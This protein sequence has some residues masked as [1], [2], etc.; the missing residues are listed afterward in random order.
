MRQ[1][2]PASISARSASM[3][4]RRRRCKACFA[5]VEAEVGPVAVCLFNAGSNVNKPLLETTEK[6]ITSLGDSQLRAARSA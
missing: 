1:G 6:L 5:R 3:P 2:Y 4:A